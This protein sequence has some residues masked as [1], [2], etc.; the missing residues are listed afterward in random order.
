MAFKVRMW[1]EK[2]QAGSRPVGGIAPL[3]KCRRPSGLPFTPVD[4][5][6]DDPGRGG[7]AGRF[8]N[9]SGYVTSLL[10]GIRNTCRRHQVAAH[11]DDSPPVSSDG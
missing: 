10:G 1:P 7:K 6:N 2:H 8:V 5:R 9:A 3:S 4:E 11:D